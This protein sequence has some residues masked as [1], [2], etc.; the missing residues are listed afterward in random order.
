MKG[1]IETAYETPGDGTYEEWY[2]KLI[3]DQAPEGLAERLPDGKD[4]T[5]TERTVGKLREPEKAL[6]HSIQSSTLHRL[7]E[8]EVQNKG[9]HPDTF[10]R[11]GPIKTAVIQ[12]ALSTG[13]ITGKDLKSLL[14]ETP[15]EVSTLEPHQRTELR[16]NPAR[17]AALLEPVFPVLDSILKKMPA[18]LLAVFGPAASLDKTKIAIGELVTFNAIMSP[19]QLKL[20]TSGLN[21]KQRA[22]LTTL[23]QLLTGALSEQKTFHQAIEARI[24]ESLQPKDDQ[25]QATTPQTS[26]DAPATR[27]TFFGRIFP[28]KDTQLVANNNNAVPE[29]NKP[30]AAAPSANDD[31]SIQDS[32]MDMLRQEQ[33]SQVPPVSNDRSKP[34]ASIVDTASVIDSVISYVDQTAQMVDKLEKSSCERAINTACKRIEKTVDLDQVDELKAGEL[35]KKL[36]ILTENAGNK[37]TDPDVKTRI[38]DIRDKLEARANPAPGR[39]L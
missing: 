21:G 25:K 18:E 10:I 4:R 13:Y 38:S 22:T 14:A 9:E 16:Q 2:W 1:S 35:L 33:S 29:G 32:F 7:I 37:I 24:T 30:E 15:K 17:S 31:N 3:R 20:E 5:S 19:I 12:F 26:P 11:E 6:V 34:E 27:R 39:N 23:T 28:G 36:D 8:L